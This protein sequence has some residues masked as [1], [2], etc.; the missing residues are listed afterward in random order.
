MTPEEGKFLYDANLDFCPEALEEE[1]MINV[2]MILIFR[3]KTRQSIVRRHGQ[4]FFRPFDQEG[5]RIESLHF[6]MLSSGCILAA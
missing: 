5:L 3:T 1:L 4:I 2:F 6:R